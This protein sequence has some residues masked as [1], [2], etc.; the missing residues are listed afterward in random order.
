MESFQGIVRSIRRLKAEMRVKNTD[1]LRIDVAMPIVQLSWLWLRWPSWINDA[2]ALARVSEI[3]CPWWE[4]DRP[5]RSEECFIGR[6]DIPFKPT[7][8]RPEEFSVTGWTTD[9]GLAAMLSRAP[10]RKA[11]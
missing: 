10:E 9:E 6:I 2:Q 7:I 8:T 3:H 4:E 1:H 5:A 11:A